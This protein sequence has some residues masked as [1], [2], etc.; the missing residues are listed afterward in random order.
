MATPVITP[1]D[2]FTVATAV[3]DEEKL[4]PEVV[5]LN[6][7]VKPTHTV[8]VPVKAF[9]VGLAFTVTTLVTVVVQPLPF[10]TA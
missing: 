10:V 5:E 4:P 3:L 1:V 9:T 8:L 7:V 6:V 2:E